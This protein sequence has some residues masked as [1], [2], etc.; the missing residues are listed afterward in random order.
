MNGDIFREIKKVLLGK[1][2]LW[3]KWFGGGANFC[4]SCVLGFYTGTAG[5]SRNFCEICWIH[6]KFDIRSRQKQL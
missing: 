1:N 6:N 3:K 5:F 2:L 4:D